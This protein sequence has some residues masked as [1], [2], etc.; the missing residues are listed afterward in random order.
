M[1]MLRFKYKILILFISVNLF[2]NDFLEKFNL[3]DTLK[4]T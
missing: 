2:A 4:K 3:D 1:G